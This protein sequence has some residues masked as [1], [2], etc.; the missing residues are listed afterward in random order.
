MWLIIVHG[1]LASTGIVWFFVI[2]PMA[3]STGP[4]D[5]GLF[6]P[7]LIFT[8]FASAIIVLIGPAIMQKLLRLL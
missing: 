2:W 5:P 8:L 4:T 6:M 3:M 7:Y 1:F